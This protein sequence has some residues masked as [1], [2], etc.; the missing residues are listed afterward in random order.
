MTWIGLP[1]T[2]PP[3]SATAISAA[4][5]EPAPV[6]VAAGPHRSVSTPIFTTSSETWALAALLAQAKT[7]AKQRTGIRCIITLPN[8]SN[9]YWALDC[10]HRTTVAISGWGLWLFKIAADGSRPL[11]M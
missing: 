10:I 2:L 8:L 4:A 5:T 9:Y 11:R 7:A 6:G 1:A 3:K